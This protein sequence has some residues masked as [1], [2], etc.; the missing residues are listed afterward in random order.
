MPAIIGDNAMK[1]DNNFD[2]NA[3]L[4]LEINLAKGLTWY[5][6]GAARLQSNKSLYDRH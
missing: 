5:T 6:K 4:W 3:Q 1:R 2:I